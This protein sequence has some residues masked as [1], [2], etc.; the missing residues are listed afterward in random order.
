[1]TATTKTATKTRKPRTTPASLIAA[2]FASRQPVPAPELAP[3]AAPASPVILVFI[4]AVAAIVL[5]KVSI[6]CGRIAY[7]SV[8]FIATKII[9]FVAIQRGGRVIDFRVYDPIFG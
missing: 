6:G 5:F 3:P 9:N 4:L 1:M 2:E 7:Q 8:K